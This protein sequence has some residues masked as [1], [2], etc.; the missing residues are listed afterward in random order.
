MKRT[1]FISGSNRGIGK[2]MV[3]AFVKAGYNVVAHSRKK[4]EVLEKEYVSIAEEN[5]VM[6][7]F[8]Y[9]DMLDLNA[10]KEQISKLRKEKI[11]VDTLVNNAGV[12]HG[13]L[14]QMTSINTIRDVFDVN[15]FS[16]LELTQTLLR[17]MVKNKRG[18]IINIAS[19]S[20]FLDSLSA[21]YLGL[22][23]AY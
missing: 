6:I 20:G 22:N 15:F 4:D 11:E 2:A 13:G 3:Y 7:R 10:M 1:V 19:I 23:S 17:P 14:F 18:C 16:H 12:A 21:S 5:N 9:F 8:V